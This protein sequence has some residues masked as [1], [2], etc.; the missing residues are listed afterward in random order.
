MLA[1]EDQDWKEGLRSRCKSS[2]HAGLYCGS[3]V[4]G[5]GHS[6]P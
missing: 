5:A 4:A 2:H 3:S 6:S 1:A